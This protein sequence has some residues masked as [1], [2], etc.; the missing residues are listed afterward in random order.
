ML[1]HNFT[2]LEISMVEVNYTAGLVAGALLSINNDE[3]EVQKKTH[4][5]TR[6]TSFSF[7][8]SVYLPCSFSLISLILL[9]L[10]KNRK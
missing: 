3:S 9:I 10:R 1:V 5:L 2:P 6:M 4:A 7:D 8:I